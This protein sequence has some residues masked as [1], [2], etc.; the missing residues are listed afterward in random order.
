MVLLPAGSIRHLLYP[1]VSTM[2]CSIAKLCFPHRLPIAY[3]NKYIYIYMYIYVLFASP[4]SRPSLVPG[5]GSVPGQPAWPRTFSSHFGC[6]GWLYVHSTVR[7]CM[8]DSVIHRL[9]MGPATPELLFDR[10]ARSLQIHIPLPGKPDNPSWNAVHMQ[11]RRSLVFAC[12]LP[13]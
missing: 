10:Q 12:C 9:V 8:C 11:Q 6:F 3:Y 13:S 7:I 4:Q 2:P 5:G 1:T